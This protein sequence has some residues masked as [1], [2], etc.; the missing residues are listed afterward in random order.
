MDINSIN[1]KSI[2]PIE[3]DK[4]SLLDGLTKSPLK[5]P[6]T[7]A[8]QK[9]FQQQLSAAAQTPEHSQSEEIQSEVSQLQPIEAEQTT[10]KQQAQQSTIIQEQQ[11]AT[12]PAEVVTQRADVLQPQQNQQRKVDKEREDKQIEVNAEASEETDSLGTKSVLAGERATLTGKTARKLSADGRP[13]TEQEELEETEE[14]EGAEQPQQAQQSQGP[15]AQP[16]AA[17]LSAQQKLFS[18]NLKNSLNFLRNLRSLNKRFSP[19]MLIYDE[20]TGYVD[21]EKTLEALGWEDISTITNTLFNQL[22]NENLKKIDYVNRMLKSAQSSGID[23]YKAAHPILNKQTN[24]IAVEKLTG[25]LA[26]LNSLEEMS[27]LQLHGEI[28]ETDQIAQ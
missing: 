25:E 28:F 16:K 9:A 23:L 24:Y 15:Q 22:N 19:D 14:A 2:G 8:A 27:K 4:G 11:T 7:S 1:S 20:E 18:M 12:Q 3:S 17:N 6:N 13:L 5:G 10:T 26:V 21:S